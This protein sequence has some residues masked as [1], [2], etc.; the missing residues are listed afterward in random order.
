MQVDTATP[1]K[2]KQQTTFREQQI[3]LCTKEI[4]AF[5]WGGIP[6]YYR[7]AEVFQSLKE[8]YHKND[9]DDWGE[10]CRRAFEGYGRDVNRRLASNNYDL[11]FLRY[12]GSGME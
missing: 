6:G 10:S 5:L 2:R 7:L 3:E 9:D 4:R 12:C 11:T 1:K 8:E